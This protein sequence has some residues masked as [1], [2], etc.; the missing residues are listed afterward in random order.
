MIDTGTAYDPRWSD[1][2]K[3]YIRRQFLHSQ[4]RAPVPI[5]SL[6]RRLFAGVGL[7]IKSIFYISMLR[8]CLA[9]MG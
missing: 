7:V 4:F 2:N 3:T 5:V 6:F 9:F 1:E 8:M